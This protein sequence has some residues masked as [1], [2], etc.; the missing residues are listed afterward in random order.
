MRQ[1]LGCR[2]GG[3]FAGGFTTPPS[4]GVRTA[5]PVTI[6]ALA[7]L[8]AVA[9]LGGA[10]CA[11]SSSHAASPRSTATP[12]V[13]ATPSATPTALDMQILRALGGQAQSVT[14]APGSGAGALVVT[15]TI[16]GTVPSTQADIAAAQ[17]RVKT[18]CYQALH[19]LLTGGRATGDV[20]IV[21]LGPM[22]DEY[23]NRVNNVYGSAIVEP[24]TAGR[25][26]WAQLTPDSAWPLYDH[27]F[28]CDYFYP[29]D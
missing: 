29:V 13:Y 18:L 2:V 12:T 4:R 15:I 8:A 9:C 14:T 21:V 10:G 5:R 25:L 6:I 27:V 1:L 3:N 19:A 28:L 24:R 22:L 23:A 20:T 17:E 7:V 16:S 26:D 11:G